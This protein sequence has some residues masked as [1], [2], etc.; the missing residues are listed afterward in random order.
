[1]GGISFSAVGGYNTKKAVYLVCLIGFL[2][3]C[4]SVPV[5]FLSTKYPVYALIWLLLFFGAFLLP[6]ITGM[7]LNSVPVKVRASAN[8]IAVLAYNMLG[9]LPAPFIYGYVSTLGIDT[10]NTDKKVIKYQTSRASRWALGIVMGWTFLSV[11]C[12]LIAANIKLREMD[13]K[14][15]K[16]EEDEPEDTPLSTRHESFEE[17]PRVQRKSAIPESNMEAYAAVIGNDME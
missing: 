16:G 2:C 17:R 5:P 4:V 14:S 12:F 6:T 11:G 9:N 10:E 7:M 8:A 15:L 13:E 3:L 1:M